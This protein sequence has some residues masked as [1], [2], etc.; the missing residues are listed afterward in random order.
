[1]YDECAGDQ[2]TKATMDS[3]TIRHSVRRLTHHVALDVLR[4]GC[5]PAPHA[6]ASPGAS[7]VFA[8]TKPAMTVGD[9][10]YLL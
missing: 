9:Q 6:F 8:P 3:L 2:T 10:N 5:L 7:S 1:V 4:D